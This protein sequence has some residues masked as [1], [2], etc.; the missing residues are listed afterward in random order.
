L[1]ELLDRVERG[2]RITITRHGRPVA[3]LVPPTGAPDLT[4]DEAIV[5]LRSFRAGHTLAQGLTIRDLIT[6]GR[7]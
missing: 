1:S 2:E 6:E 7:R 4:V 5:E 3:D